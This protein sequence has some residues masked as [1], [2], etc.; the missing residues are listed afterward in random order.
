[1][2]YATGESDGE[3]QVIHATVE[4]DKNYYAA[5]SGEWLDP[6]KVEKG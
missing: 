2:A 6:S 4:W 3:L 5:K 1:M